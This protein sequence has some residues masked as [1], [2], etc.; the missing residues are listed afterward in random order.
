M[1]LP[2]LL[3]LASFAVPAFAEN[4]ALVIAN[5]NYRAGTDIAGAD[6]V[7]AARSAL[8]AAGFRVIAGADLG[9]AAQR[10]ALSQMLAQA[11]PAERLVIVLAGHFVNSGRET[12]FLGVDARR[13]DLATAGGAGLDLG[14]VLE[15]AAAAPG[16]AV[17]LLGSEAR[18]FTLGAGLQPGIGALNIPQGVSVVSGEASAIAA[19]A[20]QVLPVAGESLRAKLAA[21]P[22]LLTQG[23]PGDQAHF[24]PAPVV[25]EEVIPNVPADA[26]AAERAFWDATRVQGTPEAYESYLARYPNG[27]FAATARSE[28]IRLRNDPA[29]LAQQAEIALALNRDARREVQRQLALLGYDPRGIDGIFGP[30]T[31]AALSSW[32]ADSGF[33]SSGYINGAQRERLSAQAAIRAEELEA[34]ARARQIEQ[35]RLDQQYWAETGAA[36]DEAGLRAYLRRLPDGLYADVAQQRLDVIMTGRQ[37][38]AAEA[39]R[40]AWRR[41]QDAD[42]LRAYEAYLAALPNGAFADAARARIA[43]LR[44]DVQ[45]DPA[46][47]A[48]EAGEAALNLAPIARTLAE[49]RLAQLGLNPGPADGEFDD[50]TRRAIRRYQQARGLP[51]TGY[52]DQAMM[53]QLL[54]GGFFSLGE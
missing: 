16:G 11:A 33:A 1:R 20:V 28:A 25:R 36:G 15:I 32:Q 35:D 19:F 47:A 24:L 42:T 51:V 50:A 41:A 4:R 3:V 52:L 48:A 40:A 53:A 45:V 13:P 49:A 12:W 54:A 37:Q 10:A 18:S 23:Y 44:A 5:E 7:M 31:R 34:A 17:V 9:A 21:H 8:E 14:T 26:F 39:D 6:D 27:L 43:A 46:Q 22:E 2:L 30:G 38:G 29:R